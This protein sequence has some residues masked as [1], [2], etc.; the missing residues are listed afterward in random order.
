MLQR[1]NA[2][3]IDAKMASSPRLAVPDIDY[4]PA[5]P[6][7]GLGRFALLVAIL[8]AAALLLTWPW[9]TGR[10]AI[11]WDAKGHFQ[12][13]VAFLAQSL[14]SGQSPFWAPYVFGGHPQIADPQSMIFSPAHL[15]LA[16]LTPNPTFEM[17]DAVSFASLVFGAIGILGYGRDR[18]WHPAATIV[19]ALCFAFGGAAAW[20]IQHT[21]Q[22]M[23]LAYFPWALWMLERGLRLGSAR[24]GA[25]SGLFAAL[26]VLDPDQVSYLSLI[27]LA[28]VVIGHWLIGPGRLARFRLSIRPLLA[29]TLV[30]GLAISIPI[31]MVLSFADGSNRAHISLKDAALG[32][33]HPSNLLTLVIANL[34][35]VIGRGE[36]FWGAPSQHWPYIVWSV[37]SRNMVAFYMGLLPL[38]G[39][40]ASLSAMRAHMRHVVPL[41]GVFAFMLLYALGDNTPF[42]AAIY[43]FFPGV[44]LFRRPADALFMIGA[45]GALL[46]G[47]GLNALLTG[48]S[49]LARLRPAAITTLL[50]VGFC[51]LAGL[52][53]A[54]WL[55]KIGL[56]LPQ[57]AIALAC[58]AV[59]F[60][61]LCYGVKMAQSAPMR[62]ALIFAV[63]L[64]AD[65]AWNIRPNESTGLQTTEYDA[66]NPD[67]DN[68][69]LQVLKSRIVASGDRRDRVELA[70]LGFIWPNLGLVHRFENSL[71]YNPLRMG[72]Y[73]AAIGARDHVAGWDQRKFSALMPGYR[74]AFSNL[75][76]LR[77]IATGVPIEKIDPSLQDNPLPL[78]AQTPDGYIYENPDALPRV[79]V[80]PEARALD[81]D[82]LVRDGQW[83]STD[84]RK[85]AY[86]EPSALPLPRKSS[87]GS[88][89]ITHYENTLVEV[90]VNAPKGGV[91]LLNDVWHP[92]WFATID[93]MPTK[94][95]RANGVF[96]AVVLPAGA[97]QVQFRFEPLRGLIRRYLVQRGLINNN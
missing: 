64:T 22:I 46:A 95:L 63:V 12:A 57:I 75:L 73:S 83:P 47:F 48:Q 50:I 79:M 18:R 89:T 61:A 77:Y 68:A 31:L 39:L 30:G 4:R 58:V 16:A 93:G 71:G 38:A 81:Q 2:R 29:G 5:P 69:T 17:V 82:S 88:A 15:L 94:I 33:V 56:A 53:M 85:I 65:L 34:Y 10:V 41:L 32:S 92:W 21:G 25:L 24:Y 67:S 91:L 84:F 86:V 45:I 3:E 20:R 51:S 36:D 70:G 43:E 60:A 74:S 96:R 78:I 28:M 7:L 40:V 27:A 72:F 76:G 19:A 37:L 49:R 1:A 52:G 54:I 80:V 35:G 6:S 44:D 42:F 14:H 90:E 62:V 66:L 9:L 26:F 13:Q 8:L 55:D 87:G 11:P 23:S 97:K 59:T